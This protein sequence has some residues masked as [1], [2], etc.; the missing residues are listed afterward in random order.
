M[1]LGTVLLG[2]DA[3]VLADRSL[4]VLLLAS[5]IGPLAVP[6]IS[7]LLN[8]LV[9]VF[10]VSPTRIG[11]LISVLTAPGIVL[12]PAIGVLTDRIG[13]RPVLIGSLLV[14][15]VAG[16][17]I[18]LTT[19]FEVVL[20]LRGLQGVGLAGIIP[21][22][23]TSIG[24]LYEGGREVTAQGLRFTSVGLSAVVFPAI[25]GAAVL[26]AWQVPFL[27]YALAVPVALVTYLWFEEPS[28]DR[29][30]ERDDD[31]DHLGA[32]VALL[33][34][35]P[36]A[37]MLV[38]HSFLYVTWIGFLTFN[39][40]IVV[41]L[42]GATPREAGLLVTLMSVA[43]VLAAS[44]AGRFQAAAGNRYYPIVGAN[45]LIGVGYALV[46]LVPTLALAAGGVFL[47]GFGFGINGSLYRSVITGF[48]AD[49]LR[50]GVVS[51]SESL[52]RVTTSVTPIAMGLLV[53][54]AAGTIGFDAAVRWTMVGAAVVGALGGLVAVSVSWYA[55]SGSGW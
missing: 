38:G 10:G 20:L 35:R 46:G 17:A 52:G 1:N 4:E 34:T 36:V 33:S 23:I 15:G 3:D 54:A 21:T 12:I 50:G 37:S 42:L 29:L 26:V 8:S 28:S 19:S 9:P 48:A 18:A 30:R 53:E 6:M 27:I 13:R 49:D 44:Q 40:I 51:V 31:A 41:Q 55:S 39:S 43:S 16:S 24:D 32:L 45:V 22:I 14:F 2:D 11:L 47:A 25:A 5:L 7:P